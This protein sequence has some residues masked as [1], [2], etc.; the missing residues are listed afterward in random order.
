LRIVQFV[1][2]FKDVAKK[3]NNEGVNE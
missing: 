2:F 1:S 3:P